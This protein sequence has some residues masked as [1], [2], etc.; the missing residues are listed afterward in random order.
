MKRKS[1]L[2]E[3]HDVLM[4]RFPEHITLEQAS[5]MVGVSKSKLKADFRKEFG[6]PFYAYFR[7]KRMQYAANL[8]LETDR[9]IIDIAETVGYD[10]SSKFSKAFGD[11]MGCSPSA[12]RRN[13]GNP[14]LF[15]NGLA[16]ANTKI[17][18]ETTERSII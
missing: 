11:V 9:K 4:K 16:F 6:M 14:V 8:L 15:D 18:E 17:I 12:Y 1:Y 13:P 2:S 10:N 7:K 5:I 3:L